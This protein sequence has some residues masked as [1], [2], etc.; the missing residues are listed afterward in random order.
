MC[1]GDRRVGEQVR[2][3]E[4]IAA[5]LRREFACHGMTGVRLLVAVSG[6][7]DSVAL[8]HGLEC[9]R[10][11]L[12][13][14][15]V[16]GHF[17]H[18]FRGAESEL[19]AAWVQGLAERLG[20]VCEVGAAEPAR[21]SGSTSAIPEE[22][23]RLARYQYL[24]EVARR[25][26]C[27]V[28]CT[29]HTADDQVETILHHLLRGTGIVGLRGMPAV[30]ELSENVVLF[31]PLLR[32]RRTDLEPFLR[33]LGQDYRTDES[34]ANQEMTR[35]WLR[36]RALPLLRERFPQMDDAVLRLAHQAGEVTVMTDELASRLLAQ[37]LVD[38]GPEAAR[39]NAAVLS[40][41]PRHLVREMFVKLWER[42][43]WPRGEMT[44]DRWNELADLAATESG[45]RMF[46]G[47][48]SARRSGGLLTI[49][50]SLDVSGRR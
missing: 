17:N 16:V 3:E 19:D 2:P 38:D 27:V 21:G 40:G 24:E 36:H 45:T 43:G 50:S 26:G 37:A 28:I 4:A 39:L 41:Q 25:R 46:P 8:L 1:S 22:A 44:Y 32:L 30:R 6:G 35:N 31:R 13:L 7:A 18:R 14:D 12:A 10:Q 5:C 23:A 20:L 34:N 48:I 11:E 9:V 42:R 29:G 47:A 15:L 49:S 33:E